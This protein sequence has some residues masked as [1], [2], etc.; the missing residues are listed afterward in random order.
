VIDYATYQPVNHVDLVAWIR[1][2]GLATI[3]FGIVAWCVTLTT[4]Y[5][6]IGTRKLSRVEE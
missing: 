6:L 4:G 1:R 5:F 3:L 2:R